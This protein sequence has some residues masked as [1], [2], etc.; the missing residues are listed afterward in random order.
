MSTPGISRLGLSHLELKYPKVELADL[1]GSDDIVVLASGSTELF[2]G[3]PVVRLDRPAWER[4]RAGASLWKRAGGRRFLIVG[5]PRVG[6]VSPSAEMAT[7][8]MT[9]GIPR[10]AIVVDDRGLT[11]REGF[12]LLDPEALKLTPGAWLVTS[13]VHLPRALQ[14]ARKRGLNFRPFPCDYLFTDS[15]GWRQWI[16]GTISYR[17]NIELLHEYIGS[18]YYSLSGRD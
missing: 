18:I 16:P 15:P 3:K 2:A 6:T 17:L 12:E 1:S 5:G 8:A 9:L 13:A 7:I 4:I 10:D 11:T 14:S